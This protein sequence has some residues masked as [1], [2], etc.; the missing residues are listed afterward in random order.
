MFY[1]GTAW[2]RWKAPDQH[3]AGRLARWAPVLYVEPPVSIVSRGR[4]FRP[5][6]PG[7]SSR[8]RG[9]G[10]NLAAFTPVVLP[11]MSRG[12]MRRVT[13]SL[14]RVL[15]AGIVRRLGADVEVAVSASPFPLFGAAGERRRVLYATD[16]FRAGASLMGVS[17]SWLAAREDAALTEAHTVIAVSDYLAQVLHARGARDPVVIENGVDYELFAA[18]DEAPLPTD[19]EL[20][21]P[22]VGFVGHLSDRIDLAVLEAVAATGRSLLLV[23]PRQGTFKLARVEELFA[24]P[25]V[26]WVGPKPFET[27]PSYLRITD[28]GLLPYVDSEF[29]RSS[30]PLKV[31]EYLAAGRPA[32]C[33]SLPAVRSLGD[34]VY[35]ADGPEGFVQ[36]VERLVAA[37][38]DPAARA[39]RQKIARGYS[40]DSVAR[41]FA[42]TIGIA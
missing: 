1:A 39:E 33:T 12:P 21:R 7:L 23:G 4:G 34:A 16:D 22:I 28:V 2:D 3:I 20:P 40:W 32:L 38:D 30:F 27:L 42:E 25:N 17:R 8:L 19:V 9:V 14:V 13:E 26:Q 36:A 31:L 5:L 10:D 24:R 41:R 15:T 35:V 6:S 29:N 11:P 37:P 18:T